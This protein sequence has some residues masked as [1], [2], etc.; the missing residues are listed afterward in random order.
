MAAEDINWSY[1]PEKKINASNLALFF[2]VILVL[3]PGVMYFIAVDF[4]E[5]TIQNMKGAQRGAPGFIVDKL[6]F[7]SM[8]GIDQ[9][10]LIIIEKMLPTE[11]FLKS[12]QVLGLK[13][14]ATNL[15][16]L[17]SGLL[18]L[19]L[20]LVV[21][22]NREMAEIVSEKERFSIT[23][24]VLDSFYM[25]FLALIISNVNTIIFSPVYK[26]YF[27]EK[28]KAVPRDITLTLSFMCLA[29][30]YVGF[31]APFDINI[32]L[33][34][35]AAVLLLVVAELVLYRFGIVE[36]MRVSYSIL[37]NY[38]LA[39]IWGLLPITLSA[40]LMLEGNH[41]GIKTLSLGLKDS[42]FITVVLLAYL[43]LVSVFTLLYKNERLLRR[44]QSR[45]WNVNS[46]MS[47]PEII[48]GSSYRELNPIYSFQGKLK[49]D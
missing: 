9:V 26:F 41:M 32:I 14:I 5:N 49:S 30:Y 29:I 17:V 36:P 22:A 35:A 23:K 18:F 31:F 34:M 21:A 2:V 20:G 42:L 27:K 46:S 33:I 28:G 43:I 12:H 24:Q 39:L 47:A 19:F 3:L 37:G 48:L 16:F 38:F 1:E 7:V 40:Y 4:Y 13:F 11:G 15:Y 8:L 6:L 25:T 10:A 45:V 44:I